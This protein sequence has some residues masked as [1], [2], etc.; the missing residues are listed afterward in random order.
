VPKPRFFA[1]RKN[2]GFRFLGLTRQPSPV[3][4]QG[5]AG[6]EGRGVAGQVEHRL[7][8]IFRPADTP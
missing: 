1:L 4:N 7:G 6:D 8:D 2:L 3:H 5:R